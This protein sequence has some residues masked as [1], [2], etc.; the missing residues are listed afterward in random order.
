MKTE[1]VDFMS[2][3]CRT[4]V[5]NHSSSCYNHCSDHCNHFSNTGTTIATTALCSVYSLHIITA[6]E[7]IR[8]NELTVYIH[9]MFESTTK[10]QS[11]HRTLPKNWSVEFCSLDQIS[12]SSAD[13]LHFHSVQQMHHCN[14]ANNAF[15]CRP[16][17]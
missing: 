9:K 3:V 16:S 1:D 8:K 15:R 12:A 14:T 17:F 4:V 2:S 6:S 13:L 10:S 11:N 5:A 7:N